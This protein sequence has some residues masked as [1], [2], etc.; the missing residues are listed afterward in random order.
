L[1][2]ICKSFVTVIVYEKIE[3]QEKGFLNYANPIHKLLFPSSTATAKAA[4][5]TASATTLTA[6]ASSTASEGA[7]ATASATT[8]TIAAA[9]TNW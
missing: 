8:I 1:L 3:W 2:Y 5:A 6:A 4:K 9:A 7:K